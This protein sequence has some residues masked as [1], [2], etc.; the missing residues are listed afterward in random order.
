VQQP[1][2]NVPIWSYFLQTSH[3]MP[4]SEKFNKAMGIPIRIL[5]N[6]SELFLLFH[7]FFGF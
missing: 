1:V 6:I 2:I 7:I 3:I 5:A 4:P